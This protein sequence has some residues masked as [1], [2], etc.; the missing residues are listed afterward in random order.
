LYEAVTLLE[1]GIGDFRER[2][3]ERT[4]QAASAAA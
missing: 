3:L 4:R 2:V 1:T